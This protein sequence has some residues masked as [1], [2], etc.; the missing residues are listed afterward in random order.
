[1]ALFY[2]A[3]KEAETKYHKPILEKETLQ[4]G[5]FF[6]MQPCVKWQSTGDENTAINRSGRKDNSI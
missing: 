2:T 3:R 6:N 1:M 5:C 4:T